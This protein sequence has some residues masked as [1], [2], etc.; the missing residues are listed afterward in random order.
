MKTIKIENAKRN[1]VVAYGKDHAQAIVRRDRTN[2]NLFEVALVGTDIRI[3][4]KQGESVLIGKP[5][6]IRNP[7]TCDGNGKG[8]HTTTEYLWQMSSVKTRAECKACFNGRSREIAA[9]K[10]EG[11]YV[12]RSASA[13]DEEGNLTDAAKERLDRLEADLKAAARKTREDMIAGV[14]ARTA[15]STATRGPAAK[16]NAY[17]SARFTAQCAESGITVDEGKALVGADAN[18][19]EELSWDAYRKAFPRRSAEVEAA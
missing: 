16:R 15:T 6:E 11:V 12:P 14:L 3:E 13:V 10:K 7:L 2:H 17:N 8:Y 1:A 4:H 9:E 18:G 5:D 19:I